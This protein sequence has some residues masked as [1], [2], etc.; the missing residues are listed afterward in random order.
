MCWVLGVF[1]TGSAV[2]RGRDGELREGTRDGGV[3]GGVRGFP[4]SCGEACG[5]RGRIVDV[6]DSEEDSLEIVDGGQLWGIDATLSVGYTCLIN[7]FRTLTL[8][9]ESSCV[10]RSPNSERRDAGIGNQSGN[11]HLSYNRPWLR[12]MWN[13]PCRLKKRLQR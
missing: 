1:W 13:M 3:C 2:A 11:V 6:E 7:P 5:D 12:G 4:C 10:A 9:A 8:R